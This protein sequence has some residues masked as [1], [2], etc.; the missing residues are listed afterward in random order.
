MIFSKLGIQETIL[1]IKLQKETMFEHIL[2]LLLLSVKAAETCENRYDSVCCKED[3]PF[4]AICYKNQSLMSYSDFRENCCVET[5]LKS[6]LF[7][8]ETMPPCILQ[9]KQNNLERFIDFFKNGK[10]Y[11]VIPVA[12]GIG[13]VVLFILYAC[14][15]FGSKSPPVKYKHIVG[16]LLD[17]K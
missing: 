9:I 16:R 6:G 8:N 14:F 13:L 7:C 10:L 3:C 12:V 15:I 1:K 17:I 4:C 5:I 2:L 11:V